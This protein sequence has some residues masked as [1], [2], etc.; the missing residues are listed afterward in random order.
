[1]PKKTRPRTLIHSQHVKSSETLLK[2]SR[3]IFCHIFGSLWKIFSSKN[4]FLVVSQTWS[5]FLN[6]L[7]PYDKYS[8]SVKVSFSSKQ[9]KVCYLEN[10]K[11]LLNFLQ[12]F[13]NLH[14]IS[15][16]LKKKMRLIAD[17]LQKLETAKSV[18]T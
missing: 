6:I 16:I 1:M 11:L 15:N 17:V 12:H 13:W 10:W 18:V 2:F 14:Q 4:S 3:Q 7:T 9:L 5:L 8:L